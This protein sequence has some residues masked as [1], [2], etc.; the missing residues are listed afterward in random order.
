MENVIR[1]SADP[2]HAVQ[3][4]LPWYA[5]GQIDA[6]DKDQVEAHL[7]TCTDCQADL[8]LEQ[9]LE[10]KVSG[11]SQDVEQG[12]ASMLRLLESAP[13]GRGPA[14]QSRPARKLASFLKAGAPW[15]GWATAAAIALLAIWGAQI[16]Q[17]TRYHALSAPPT[18]V[19]GNMVVIFRPD[20]TEAAIR[21]ALRASHA[22][23][24]DG[25]TAADAYVLQTSADGRARALASL[26]TRRSVVLA[27]PV[28]N[29][30]TP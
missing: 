7:I 2:H 5:S 15:L 17:P 6:E 18:H 12:W 25:P 13:T 23:L 22:R 30:S 16:A 11:L 10:L 28:D 4:L 1:F 24:V 26:R 20:A 29:G 14:R 21:Q 27:E 9:R 19:Q 3:L 8:R